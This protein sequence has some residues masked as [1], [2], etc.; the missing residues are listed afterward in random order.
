[1]VTLTPEALSHLL[2]YPTQS[3]PPGV[4]PNFTNPYS[5]A[6]QVYIT[7]SLCIILMVVFS[8]I[9]FVSKPHYSSKINLGDES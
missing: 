6:Y 4:T 1:M 3:P 5:V 9:R 8:V 2:D 7:A